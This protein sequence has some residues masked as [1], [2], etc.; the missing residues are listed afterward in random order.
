MKTSLLLLLTGLFA[1]YSWQMV[2][3]TRIAG[4]IWTLSGSAYRLFLLSLLVV[5]IR[6]TAFRLVCGLLIVF[7]TVATAC[8]ALYLLNPWTTVPG[9]SC[10][11]R[12]NMPLGIIGAVSGLAL[13]ISILRHK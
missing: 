7:D 6:L 8:T 9:Q 13:L 1:A 10:T 12:L 4:H 11:S 5:A 3:D 2:D